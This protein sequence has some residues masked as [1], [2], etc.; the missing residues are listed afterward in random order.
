MK[1]TTNQPGSSVWAKV[2]T[3]YSLLSFPVWQYVCSSKCVY[4]WTCEM[5]VQ[6]ITA[7]QDIP[8]ETQ[9]SWVYSKDQ[10]QSRQHLIKTQHTCM[11]THTHRRR[12]KNNMRRRK[13]NQNFSSAQLT[14]LQGRIY[15]LAKHFCVFRL[16]PNKSQ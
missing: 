1:S 14:T 13:L 4:F 10:A 15:K 5:S 12:N 2:K 11:C 8:G 6:M 3:L 7:Q 9:S 16:K